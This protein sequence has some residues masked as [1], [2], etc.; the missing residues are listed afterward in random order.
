MNFLND[1]LVNGFVEEVK[2]LTN[3]I[4]S[5]LENYKISQ[6]SFEIEKS[7]NN[8]SNINESSSLLGFDALSH[9]SYLIKEVLKE[10]FDDEKQN[11]V[12]KSLDSINIFADGIVKKN[13]N[14]VELLAG[15]IKSYRRL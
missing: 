12:Q 3:E 8:A 2:N 15:V 11:F 13:L 4:K 14:Q 1:E 6:N 9:I 7:F 10:Q 5:S